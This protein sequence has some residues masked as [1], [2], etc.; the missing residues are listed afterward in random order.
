MFAVCIS[1]GFVLWNII[2]A[3]I[4]GQVG[5]K[6]IIAGAIEAHKTIND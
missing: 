6:V 2:A 4:T 1:P 5:A 3:V